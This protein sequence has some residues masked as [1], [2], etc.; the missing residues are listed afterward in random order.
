[1]RAQLTR[2]PMQWAWEHRVSG[3][4]G[5]GEPLAALLSNQNRALIANLNELGAA[6]APSPFDASQRVIA[7]IQGIDDKLRNQIN[8]AYA[9]VRNS[10]GRSASVSTEGF[11]QAAKNRLTD[12]NPELASMTSLADYLPDTIARQYN[13]I[14]TGKLPLTVDTIQFLDRAWGG[15]ARG[16]GDDTTRNAVNKLRSALNDAP[17]DDAIG[18]E[19]MEAYKAA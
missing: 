5:V 13:D 16:S 10:A 17:I 3:Q 8:E 4:Q 2:D 15:V 12:G 14:V 6:S 19:S 11:A 7:H 9:K 18:K 1:T